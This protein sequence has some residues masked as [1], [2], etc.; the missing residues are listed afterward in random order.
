MIVVLSDTHAREP[1]VL[2]EPIRTAIAEADAVIHAGDFVREPVLEAFIDRSETVYAVC[3]NVDDDAIRRRLPRERTL[4]VDG[5]SIVVVHTVRGGQ[6]G[7][8]TLGREREVDL[9][10]SGHTHDPGYVWTG[11]LGLLN[12]GSH[13]RPRGNRPAYAELTVTDGCLEG[14]LKEPDGT[15]FERFEICPD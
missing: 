13:A 11:S 8:A 9:V 12:P 2:T 4:E 1:P 7:L 6:T 5:F 10:I 15:P 3:G 14:V